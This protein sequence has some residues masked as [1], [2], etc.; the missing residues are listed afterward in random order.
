MN[1]E[2]PV[3]SKHQHPSICEPNQNKIV[4]QRLNYCP[5]D[6][7]SAAQAIFSRYVCL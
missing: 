7:Y 6:I 1:V 4:L 2:I 5:K 3:S